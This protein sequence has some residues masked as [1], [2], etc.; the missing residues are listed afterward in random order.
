[1]L[2]SPGHRRSPSSFAPSSM[3]KR[4][5][6]RL[7]REP[8]RRLR[9]K[10]L[11]ARVKRHGDHATISVAISHLFNYIVWRLAD[12]EHIRTCGKDPG[13]EGCVVSAVKKR[14]GKFLGVTIDADIL[15]EKHDPSYNLRKMIE[16]REFF[17]CM[18]TDGSG[19]GQSQIMA[20]SSL[21]EVVTGV[22]YWCQ[23]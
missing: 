1:M 21:V 16:L 14:N 12:T 10:L 8:D 4:T 9:K 3:P 15:C 20:M 11:K 6:V 22:D 17:T 5:R 19:I 23:A 18:K 2:I 13:Q 7:E